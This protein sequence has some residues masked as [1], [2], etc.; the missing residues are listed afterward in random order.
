MGEVLSETCH[1]SH[2]P[3][4]FSAEVPP[5]DHEPGAEVVL[6]YD[7]DVLRGMRQRDEFA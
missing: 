3:V 6:E 5:G 4:P 2:L 7:E 1:R